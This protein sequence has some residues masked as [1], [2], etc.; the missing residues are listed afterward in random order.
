MDVRQL[1]ERAG[2]SKPVTGTYRSEGS[3]PSLSANASA[4]PL[5]TGACCRAPAARQASASSEA[6]IT[7]AFRR[8]GYAPPIL[9]R[10]LGGT[11]LKAV[12]ET[13]PSRS[14]RRTVWVSIS[15]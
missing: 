1:V 3:N 15:C 11:S 14:S 13:R 4:V 7:R 5:Q 2:L 12:R 10:R 9:R 6:E 8:S